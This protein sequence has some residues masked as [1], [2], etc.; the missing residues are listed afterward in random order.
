MT[1]LER[2]VLNRIQSDFPLV[3]NPYGVLAEALD[4]SPA[5]IRGALAAC[6]S[7]GIIRRIGGS[8]SATHVGY[9]SALVATRVAPSHIQAV[10]QHAARFDEVTHDYERE[11]ALNLWFTVVAE[12]ADRLAAI[13]NSVRSQPGVHDLH[14]LPA[15][16]TFKLR[17]NFDVSTPAEEAA[18]G[19]NRPRDVTAGYDT[20]PTTTG[21]GSCRLDDTDRRLIARCCADIEEGSRPFTGLARDVGTTE[22]D[23]LKRLQRYLATGLMRRFGA[24]VRHQRAG[25]TA[26]AMGVW[27]VPDT[28]IERIGRTLAESQAVSH[29]YERPRFAGWPYNLYSMI[30]GRSVAE[31]CQEKEDLTRSTGI[32]E[33]HLLFTG[34]EFKKSSVRYFAQ[35]WPTV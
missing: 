32:T 27:D 31:C 8:F 14:V 13:T 3:A 26:N 16:R 5:E 29:C 7:T 35:H 34:R 20:P 6:R 21:R 10:A 30:H 28:E 19:E 4:S 17:V 12:T 33:S 25:F 24:M 15:I 11:D 23:V 1:A 18:S 9:V 2:A 22:S